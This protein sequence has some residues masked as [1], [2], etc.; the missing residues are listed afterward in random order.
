MSSAHVSYSLRPDATPETEL[1][2]LIAVYKFVL[3]KKNAASVTS[4]DGDDAKGS[5]NDRAKNSIYD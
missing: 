2:A 4:T 1:S 5:L 3:A